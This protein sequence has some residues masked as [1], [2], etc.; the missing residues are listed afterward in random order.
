VEQ[1]AQLPSIAPFSKPFEDAM[2]LACGASLA[3]DGFRERGTD[4]T[5]ITPKNF[6][7][8]LYRGQTLHSCSSLI[9]SSDTTFFAAPYGKA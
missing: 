1:V 8:M 2:G 5:R 7:A 9:L 3:K 6:E 4:F